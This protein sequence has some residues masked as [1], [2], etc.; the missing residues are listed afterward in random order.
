VADDRLGIFSRVE[1]WEFQSPR[2]WEMF[3]KVSD[4][5]FFNPA[6]RGALHDLPAGEYSGYDLEKRGKNAE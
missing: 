1:N 6:I 3:G 2:A 5:V 4:L